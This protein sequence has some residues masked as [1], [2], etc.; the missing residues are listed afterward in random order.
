MLSSSL[1]LYCLLGSLALGILLS[2]LALY[3]LL[4][5]LALNLISN[6]LAIYYHLIS[7]ALSFIP[8]L[9]VLNVPPGF[10]AFYYL[11]FSSHQVW[12][13]FEGFGL[14]LG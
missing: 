6:S 10:L 14:F 1:A 4:S 12:P 9:L 8:S 13:L 7:L 11:S 2:C 3:Y 5:F